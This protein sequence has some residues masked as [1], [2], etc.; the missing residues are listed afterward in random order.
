M[1]GVSAGGAGTDFLE[2]GGF[3]ARTLQRHC[4]TCSGQLRQ[5]LQDV[6]H[7]CSH[8][9]TYPTDCS[10]SA[11]TTGMFDAWP[12]LSQQCE[13]VYDWVRVFPRMYVK[14]GYSGC[15]ANSAPMR[16]SITHAA[17]FA[18]QMAL[19]TGLRAGVRSVRGLTECFLR[20]SSFQRFQGYTAQILGASIKL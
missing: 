7:S 12:I 5:T 8:T 10:V 15:D 14:S 3:Q 19:G 13:D 6:S 20:W 18:S 1:P 2:R 11:A 4:A 9:A 16:Q 17:P